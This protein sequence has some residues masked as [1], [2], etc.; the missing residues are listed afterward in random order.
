MER[1]KQDNFSIPVV[2]A[3]YA[4]KWVAWSSDHKKIVGSGSTAKDAFEAAARRGEQKPWLDR[5]PEKNTFFA[6]AAFRG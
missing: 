6:G 4:G 3:K 2:P 5:V 1:K